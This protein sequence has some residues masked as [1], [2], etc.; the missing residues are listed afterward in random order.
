LTNC[1]KFKY[2]V[3]EKDFVFIIKESV[4]DRLSPINGTMLGLRLIDISTDKDI[5]W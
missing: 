4:F 1:V 2:L 3:L 5:Y